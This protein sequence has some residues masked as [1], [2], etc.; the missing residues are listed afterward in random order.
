MPVLGFPESPISE[1]IESETVDTFELKIRRGKRF[2]T[3]A[4]RA[5]EGNNLS[6]SG[7]MLGDIEVGFVSAG[8]ALDRRSGNIVRVRPENVALYPV[9][10]Q[11][12]VY[13][14]PDSQPFK[15]PLQ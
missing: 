11:I 3:V 14:L 4:A 5:I 10:N 15:N 13:P 1:P 9:R 7:L 8:R 6:D 2:R 12:Q